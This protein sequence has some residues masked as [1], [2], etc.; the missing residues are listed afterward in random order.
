MPEPPPPV[1]PP[2]PKRDGCATA[3]MV[4]FGIILL[5][6]GLCA[7]VFG[8]G[9]LTSSSPDSVVTLLVLLGLL[10]GAGGVLLIRAA[11]RGPRP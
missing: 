8:F 5:L 7:I 3:F 11:I 1:P 10:V 6:P 2:P 9:N 4:L